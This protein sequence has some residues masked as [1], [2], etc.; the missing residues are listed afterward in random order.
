MSEVVEMVD[1]GNDCVGAEEG[2]FISS[3]E[4]REDKWYKA[5]PDSLCFA[6][7]RQGSRAM[8]AHQSTA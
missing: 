5:A 2:L 6:V 7:R 3:V 1:D 8:E 4:A